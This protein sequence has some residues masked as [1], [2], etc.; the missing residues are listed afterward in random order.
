[1][2][3]NPMVLIKRIIESII[4]LIFNNWKIFVLNSGSSAEKMIELKI[5][6]SEPNKD[7]IGKIYAYIIIDIF[8]FILNFNHLL[9]IFY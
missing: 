9:K 4:E 2:P 1:M 3:E 6:T 7:K 5:L 8:F